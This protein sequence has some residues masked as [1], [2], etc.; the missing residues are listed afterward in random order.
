MAKIW[1][2]I[3]TTLGFRLRGLG[4]S[5]VPWTAETQAFHGAMICGIH[6]LFCLKTTE[7]QGFTTLHFLNSIISKTLRPQGTHCSN[8]NDGLFGGQGST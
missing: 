6:I 4:C 2:N 1:L 5:L 7:K 8:T 3:S